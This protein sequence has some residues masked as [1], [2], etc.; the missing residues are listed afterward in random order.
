MFSRATVTYLDGKGPSG[1]ATEILH[2]A[3]VWQIA[4]FIRDHA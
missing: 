2:L 3:G 4:R 1:Q